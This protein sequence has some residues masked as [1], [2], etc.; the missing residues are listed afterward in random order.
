[1]KSILFVDDEPLLLSAISRGLRKDRER[2]HMVF[3]EDARAALKAMETETFNAVVTDF[4][5]PGMDGVTFL[6]HV[7]RDHRSTARIMLSGNVEPS[8]DAMAR[9]FAHELL[10]KPC[11]IA[12][13]R[14]CLERQLG[15]NA[16]SSA[17]VRAAVRAIS[18][19]VLANR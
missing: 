5:M 1:M 16:T 11:S 7:R 18:D 15:C 8:I 17:R 19:R 13:L 2:W 9:T 6:Q 14:A 3:V 4:R 12:A 10:S